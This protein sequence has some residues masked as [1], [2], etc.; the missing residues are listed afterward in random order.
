LLEVS[1]LDKLL[2]QVPQLQNSGAPTAMDRAVVNIRAAVNA[3][4][5]KPEPWNSVADKNIVLKEGFDYNVQGGLWRDS[6]SSAWHDR[7][8][9]V[10]VTCPTKFE[11][12][13]YAHFHDWN[14]LDRA[15][16]LY[17]SGQDMGPLSRYDGNGFWLKLPV[18]AEMTTKG[19]ITLDA[20]VIKGPNV[21]VS[22][23]V[24]VPKE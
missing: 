3:P 17:F 21:M 18:T 11:G 22:Q 10:T 8:L 2:E 23:I 16:A 5:G 15:A 20:R 13:F 4:I 7:N 6:Q 1:T 19:L 12:T 14:N 24:L 9:I